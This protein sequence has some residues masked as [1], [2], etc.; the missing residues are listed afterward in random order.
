MPKGVLIGFVFYFLFLWSNLP[1]IAA[2]VPLQAAV[3]GLIRHD[4]TKTSAR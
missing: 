2:V 4:Y 1:F 3:G